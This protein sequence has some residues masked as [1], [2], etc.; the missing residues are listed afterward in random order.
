MGVAQRNNPPL[1]KKS[2]KAAMTNLGRENT[3]TSTDRSPAVSIVVPCRN[4]REH[5]ES[6]LKSILAQEP[7]PGNF[8]VIV[9]DGMSDDG[10]RE[11]LMKVAY[12]DERL[13]VVDNPAGITPSGMNTGI[14]QARGEFIAIMGAHNEYAPD[15]LSA[16]LRVI[17]ETGAD[18]VGGSMLC[19]GE[20][21]L[22]RAIAVAHHSPFSVGGA[23]WHDV[24]YEGPA[25]TVFG[26]FYRRSVFDRIGLFDESLLRNQD[27]ELNLRLTLSGGKIWHSPAIRS[28]Y[29][30]RTSLAALFGQYLQYGY[31]K[32]AVMKKHRRPAALRQLVPG[33]FVLALII[34]PLLA[35]VF[36]SLF[37]TWVA[38]LGAYAVANLSASIVTAART[39]W[40]FVSLL[41]II[42]GC[43]HFGYG[44][45][46]LRGL[47]GLIICRRRPSLKLTR[48]TRASE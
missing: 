31:W 38:L 41:P 33:L 27:D 13:R 12:E 17:Q 44:I 39:E 32:V 18:N 1:S 30:P 25:D 34:L 8:E 16:A 43:F 28:C 11:I 21:R 15:Y 10:T 3:N 40:A 36:P 19:R 48:L 9:A 47:L 37:I 14:R 29:S 22:Q 2:I 4:E 45:G 7:P 42:F 26:G 24:S 46:F 35:I 6:A 5:I 23:R 20:S